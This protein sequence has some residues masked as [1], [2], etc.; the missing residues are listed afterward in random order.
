MIAAEYCGPHHLSS[1]VTNGS[2]PSVRALLEGFSDAV[3]IVSDDRR[4]IDANASACRLFGCSREELLER[5]VDDFAASGIEGRWERFLAAGEECGE[6]RLITPHR[7]VTV[8][9]RA[10]AHF[11]PGLHL[12]TLRDAA[13]RN[14]TASAHCRQAQVLDQVRDAIVETDACGTVTRWN[15][16][17]ERLFLRPATEAIGQH[18]SLIFAEPSRELMAAVLMEALLRDG[19]VETELPVVRADGEPAWV[20]ASLSL[21]TRECGET[22]GAIGFLQDVTPRRLA[23]DA[24]TVSESRL[25]LAQEVGRIG[26]W[27][28]D[29]PRDVATCSREYFNIYG[30]EPAREFTFAQWAARLHPDDAPRI[31]AAGRAAQDGEDFTQEYRIIR[32]DG[33]IRWVRDT[34]RMFFGPLGRPA[35]LLGTIVDITSEKRAE[36][37]LRASERHYRSLIEGALDNTAIATADG[38]IT[39]ESPSVTRMLGYNAAELIGRNVLDFV[40]PDDVQAARRRLAVALRRNTK[41]DVFEFRFRHRDGSWRWLEAIGRNMLDDPNVGG[42][43]INSRDIT[44][45]KAAEARLRESQQRLE[46]AQS[47]AEMGMWDWN[48]PAN[49][50]SCCSEYLRMH[51]YT[52]APPPAFERWI[53]AVHAS[54]A[55]RIRAHILA[56]LSGQCSPC[57]YEIKLPD[58]RV[59]WI[60]SKAKVVVD[61]SGRPVRVIGVGLDSTH[62]KAA[63]E[64]LRESERRAS[65]AQALA[66]LG[67]WDYEIGSEE[68]TCSPETCR[69]FGIPPRSEPVEPG[70]FVGMIAPEDRDHVRQAIRRTI[71]DGTPFS[72]DHRIVRVD[73]ATRYVTSKAEL[74]V[75]GD[76]RPLRIRGT[77]QDITGRR[78]LEQQL[79][80]SQKMEAIG[81]LAGGIAHDFNNLLTVILGYANAAL[82][83]RPDDASRSQLEQIRKAGERAATLTRQLLTF[84]RQDIRKQEDIDVNAVLV[85]LASMLIPLLGEDIEVL[86]RADARDS[87]VRSAAGHLEQLLMNL[88]ANARDAM[89]EGGKVTIVTSN[90]HVEDGPDGVH[91]LCPG[92][93]LLLSVSD[94]GVG[95]DEV[96]RNRVFEPFFT[97]KERGKGTGLGLASAYATVDQCGGAISVASAPGQGTTFEIYLPVVRARKCAAGDEPPQRAGSGSTIGTVLIVE[98]EP[99]LRNLAAE[100]LTDEGC[101][102]LQAGNG[103]EA[104]AIIQSRGSSVDVIVTDVVMPGMAGPELIARTLESHPHIKVL[105]TS[106]YT[107]HALLRRGILE[108]SENF[109][110]KPFEIDALCGNVHRLLAE[111]ARPN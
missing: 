101:T 10:R 46:L 106:G 38:T 29:I 23:Q 7:A 18:V 82:R 86:I 24:L 1:A 99:S 13:C 35:R 54:N 107:D 69:I 30:I 68:V 67:Y 22:Y 40:H 75:A 11:S 15:S 27:D 97:T 74:I 14:R 57:E 42:I 44:E 81:Q 41:T 65:E 78:L 45:R 60:T 66:Q 108:N 52:G 96:V 6:F 88:A 26:F 12:W 2:E 28:I 8:E 20:H 85:E 61:S 43:V 34:A 55:K 47:A 80:Q 103:A 63:D 91:G 84:S 9:F 39:Y 94:T 70:L 104:L 3:V 31:I 4:Y 21:L 59:R 109:L 110:Q 111:A 53:A 98:D 77:I 93:Y 19:R 71:T 95:M 79:L 33:E 102:V 25:R 73:G 36:E 72:S 64:K 83:A 90:V 105:Y 62:L 48:I 5:R 37:K 87:Y 56:H 100:V 58:G 16:G 51:G 89:P 32:P 49:A 92:P 76:G 50:V 17:A